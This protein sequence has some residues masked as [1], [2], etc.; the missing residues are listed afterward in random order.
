MYIEEEP[1]EAFDIFEVAM[2]NQFKKRRKQNKGNMLA[3]IPKRTEINRKGPT[4]ILSSSCV[5]CHMLHV[6]RHGSHDMRC[7]SPVT[8]AISHSHRISPCLLPR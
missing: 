3:P 8:N 5:M 6:T 1:F 4:I 2:N 7:M